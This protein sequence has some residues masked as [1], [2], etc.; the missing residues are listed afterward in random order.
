MSDAWCVNKTCN[1]FQQIETHMHSHLRDSRLGDPLGIHGHHN[2]G[3]VLVGLSITR[4]CQ[5]A[6]PVCLWVIEVE[7]ELIFLTLSLRAN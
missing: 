1:K 4:I 2:Q 7:Y 6:R 3:L 5:E